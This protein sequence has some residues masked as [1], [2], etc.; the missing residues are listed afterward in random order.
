MWKGN[1]CTNNVNVKCERRDGKWIKEPLTV[2]ITKRC[3][4]K[5]LNHGSMKERSLMLVW[6]KEF[7]DNGN[8]ETY[9]MYCIAIHH[10]EK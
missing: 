4:S 3:W 7:Y 5:V 10:K 1:N 2:L 9:F 8:E 6:K